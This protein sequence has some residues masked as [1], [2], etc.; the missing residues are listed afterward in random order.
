MRFQRAKYLVIALAASLFL[1]PFPAQASAGVKSTF[2]YSLANFHGKLPYNEVRVRVDRARDEVYVVERGIVRVFN[3][4]GMEF[5][6]FGDNAEL[7]SIYDLAVD[8]KGDVS[9]LSFNF[10]H[11]EDPKYFLIRCNYRGEVKEKLAVTGLPIEFSG[12]FPNYMFYRDG[13]YLFLSS[14]KMQVVITDRNG[15]YRKGYDL[16]DILEIPKKDRPNTEIFGFNLDSDGN[17]LFTVPVLFQAYVVSPDGKVAGSFGKAG[18]APGMFGVV[19]GIAKDDQGNYLVVERLRSVVMVF[20]KEFRFL[21]EFGYVG[22]KPGNLIR[23]NE[24]A[25]G[26]AG[27]LYVTQVRNRGVSVF[28]V[29][30]N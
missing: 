13:E 28:S 3:E 12:F 19:C 21:Q 27:K 1:A 7:E 17:M 15:V 26:N 4:S 11:P 14:S 10:S 2:L 20:D 9:L 5:F 22:G 18:S 8:E 25:M 16:A 24:V 29:T 23:P 6:W 30:S